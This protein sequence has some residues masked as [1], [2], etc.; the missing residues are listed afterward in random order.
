MSIDPKIIQEVFDR[1]SLRAPENAVG[2]VL[3]RLS[4]RYQRAMDRAL[5]P[6]KLTNLQFV[7]LALV[8]WLGRTGQAVTQTELSR[9][10]DIHPMQISQ[11]MKVLEAKSLIRR[12]PSSADSRA[13]EL[14]ITSL[15]LKSLRLAFPAAIEVQERLFGTAGKPG[16]QLLAT[17]LRLDRKQQLAE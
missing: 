14:V 10:S 17:L 12:Q 6:L 9:F 8:A 15:G 7:T 2:F 16:G 13:K 4:A 11:V 3:W 1:H 5:L